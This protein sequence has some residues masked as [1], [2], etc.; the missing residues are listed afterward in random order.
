VPRVPAPRIYLVTEGNFGQILDARWRRVDPA[1][2]PALKAAYFQ[3]KWACQIKE[4]L[5]EGVWGRPLGAPDDVPAAEIKT[6]KALAE[7]LGVGP[8]TL[9]RKLRGE[10][11]ISVR[12]VLAVYM[13]LKEDITFLPPLEKDQLEPPT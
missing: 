8:E 3:H 2:L 4:S 6:S 5:I 1:E 10:E 13:V 9:R 7:M 12:D 11:F